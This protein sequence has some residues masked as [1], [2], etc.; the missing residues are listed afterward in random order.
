MN[1][2]VHT[3]ALAFPAALASSLAFILITSTPTNVIAYSAGYFQ[4]RILLKSELL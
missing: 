2:G 4:S 1:I 3:M